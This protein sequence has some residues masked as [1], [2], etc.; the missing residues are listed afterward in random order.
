M[1]VKHALIVAV[2]ALSLAE[3]SHVLISGVKRSEKH[4]TFL[5]DCVLTRLKVHRRRSPCA[6]G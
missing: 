6:Q 5:R 3:P 1:C 2:F 4:I